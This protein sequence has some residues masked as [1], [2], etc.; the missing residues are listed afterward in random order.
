[1]K[2]IPKIVTTLVAVGL[3][4]DAV[5]N[6][7]YR[8]NDWYTAGYMLVVFVPAMVW[9][10][11]WWTNIALFLAL[12]STAVAARKEAIGDTEAGALFLGLALVWAFLLVVASRRKRASRVAAAGPQ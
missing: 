9:S 8:T 7:H 6:A 3:L 11:M 10:E 1:M 5:V 12:E 2:R 4:C